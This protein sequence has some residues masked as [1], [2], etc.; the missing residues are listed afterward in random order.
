MKDT[1]KK[2]LVKGQTKRTS[3]DITFLQEVWRRRLNTMKLHIF[4]QLVM[5]QDID[6]NVKFSPTFHSIAIKVFGT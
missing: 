6:A 3:H 5:Q 1:L 4:L 2:Q